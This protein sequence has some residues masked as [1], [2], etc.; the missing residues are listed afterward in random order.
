MV[1]SC[2]VTVNW[3]HLLVNAEGLVV[4]VL[5][6]VFGHEVRVIWAAVHVL[7]LQE[8]HLDHDIADTLF[9][10]VKLVVCH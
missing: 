8:V 3:S 6:E 9:G 10:P 2:S 7:L 1:S 4:E 5:N